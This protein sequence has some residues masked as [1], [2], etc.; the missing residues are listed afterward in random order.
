MESRHAEMVAAQPW[1]P[2]PWIVREVIRETA[3][4]VTLGLQP[5]EGAAAMS[6]GPGQFNML[7]AFGVG[8][9]PISISGDPADAS[10]LIHTI[11]DVGL[12][13]R[14]L[15]GLQPGAL[16]GVRGPFGSCWP[17]EGQAGQDVVVAAGGIGLAPLRPV[18]YHLARHRARYGN[19]VLLYGARKPDELLF[20]VELEAWR[21]AGIQVEVTVDHADA[22]WRGN[23]GVATTLIRHARFSPRNAAAF[24]CGPEVMMRFTAAALEERGM[25]QE[26]LFISMERNMKCAVG[27]CGHCQLGPEFICMDGPV[28]AWPRMRRLMAIREL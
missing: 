14:A 6:F 23:V 13:S 9:V 10:R 21:Q 28:F 18:L 27:F 26:R 19:V 12:V 8:E 1:L 24:I 5:G 7:Y 4:V 11:R 2:Q 22:A 3:D 15:C 17:V 20:G 16:V 25:A